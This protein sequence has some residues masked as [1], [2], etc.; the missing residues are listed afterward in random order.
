MGLR[1]R[2]SVTLCKG[3]KLNFGKTGM[4]VTLGQKGYHKT[5]HQNGNVTTSV[6]IPGTGIYWTDTKKRHA[7]NTTSN[8]KRSS[9]RQY[10]S[11]EDRE[12]ID[13]YVNELEVPITE[14]NDWIKH[15]QPDKGKNLDTPSD[16]VMDDS[17]DAYFQEQPIYERQEKKSIDD[18]VYDEESVLSEE[19][20][21]SIYKSCDVPVDWTEILV[22]SSPDDVYMD[23]ELWK[24]YKSVVKDIL[25]GDIDTYLDVIEKIRPLDDLLSFG[26]DF[27]FGTDNAGLMEVEFDVKPEDVLGENYSIGLFADY[28]CAA[29]IRVARDL[30]SLLPVGIVVVHVVLGNQT[31]LSVLFNKHEM[32]RINFNMSPQSVIAQF[33]NNMNVKE[34][35]YPVNRI[36][37]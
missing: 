9:S 28:V 37:I 19:M 12:I 6:G 25:K 31:I 34:K 17:L 22:S 35:M 27:E 24:Y 14:E 7:D 26:G 23:K 2:K 3:V 29:G 13:E 33:R 36:E 30:F 1:F 10:S 20:I 5:I 21:Y 4:S 16:Y 8:N 18:I 11:G 32:Q 15:E